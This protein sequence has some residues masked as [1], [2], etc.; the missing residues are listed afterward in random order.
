MDGTQTGDPAKVGPAIDA[1]LTADRSPLRLQLGADAID[2]VRTHAEQMLGDL[3]V[4][5]AVGRSVAFD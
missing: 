1:A 5:D 3:A 2:M 4:W